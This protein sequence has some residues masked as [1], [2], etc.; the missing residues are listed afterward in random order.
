MPLPQISGHD[1]QDQVWPVH[2]AWEGVYNGMSNSVDQHDPRNWNSLYRPQSLS[3]C[4][5]SLETSVENVLS[6]PS[7]VKPY[8]P[9]W[10]APQINSVIPGRVESKKDLVSAADPVL[11]MYHQVSANDLEVNCEGRVFDPMRTELSQRHFHST[12]ETQHEHET[13]KCFVPPYSTSLQYGKPNVGSFYPKQAQ[14]TSNGGQSCHESVFRGVQIQSA[15]YPV[16]G[17]APL[18]V[19]FL[20]YN[21]ASMP[22]SYHT[23]SEGQSNEL[24]Y[25]D[26][27]NSRNFVAPQCE[28]VVPDYYNYR[29]AHQINQVQIGAPGVQHNSWSTNSRIPERNTQVETSTWGYQEMSLNQQDCAAARGSIHYSCISNLRS[30]KKKVPIL[31]IATISLRPSNKQQEKPKRHSANAVESLAQCKRQGSLKKKSLDF[32]GSEN[33]CNLSNAPIFQ[34]LCEISKA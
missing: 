11:R 19:M 33:E 7:N 5:P 6:A 9:Y 21:Q 23:R 1:G 32:E 8:Q 24:N 28:M 18:P 31:K 13:T 16:Q 12:H 30:P 4:H 26:N 15:P 3:V 20:P 27:T 17:Y 29:K 25:D 14:F 10:E 22:S 2:Q 34:I